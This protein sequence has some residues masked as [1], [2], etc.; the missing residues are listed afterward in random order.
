MSL[1]TDFLLGPL[2]QPEQQLTQDLQCHSALYK[3]LKEVHDG[4]TSCRGSFTQG[5]HPEM[6]SSCLPDH[7][8]EVL[9]VHS[10]LGATE[11]FH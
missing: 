1:A 4:T 6:F 9:N 7:N 8:Y 10:N 11:G 3:L 5:A 2:P